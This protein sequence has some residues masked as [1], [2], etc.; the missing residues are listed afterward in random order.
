M[1]IGR[2]GWRIA[3]WLVIIAFTLQSFIAQTHIHDVAII[4]HEATSGSGGTAPVDSVPLDCPFCQAVAHGGTFFL[5]TIVLFLVAATWIA[6]AE[7]GSGS[8]LAFAVAAHNWK[9]RAPPKA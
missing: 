3:I 7:F 1:R 6:S 5:P 2:Q 9:S 4:S 8:H